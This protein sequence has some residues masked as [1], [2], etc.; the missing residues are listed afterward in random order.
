MQIRKMTILSSSFTG[1]DPALQELCPDSIA[2]VRHVGK[3]DLFITF[4]VNSEWK[5]ITIELQ[6]GQSCMD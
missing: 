3:P 6:S 5:E 2:S 1:S 4:T